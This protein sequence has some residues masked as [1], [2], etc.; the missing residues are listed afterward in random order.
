MKVFGPE[1]R[2]V[3]TVELS[4]VLDSESP[5]SLLVN[6]VHDALLLV[7]KVSENSNGMDNKGNTKVSFM[8]LCGA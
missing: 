5:T 4:P 8:V 1:D 2:Y 6:S 3:V 7:V